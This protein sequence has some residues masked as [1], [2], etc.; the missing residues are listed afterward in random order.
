M[1][2]IIKIVVEDEETNHRIVVA[3]FK[4]SISLPDCFPEDIANELFKFLSEN[5]GKL[6]GVPRNEFGDMSFFPRPLNDGPFEE[7]EKT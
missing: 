5:T 3:S 1:D 7:I 6:V 2:G 4:K